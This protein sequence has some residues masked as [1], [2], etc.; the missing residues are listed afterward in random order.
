MNDATW[1]PLALS[2]RWADG[3]KVHPGFLIVREAKKGRRRCLGN[4]QRRSRMSR[5]LA[6]DAAISLG[7]S[8]RPQTEMGRD[9]RGKVNQ[10]TEPRKQSPINHNE[11]STVRR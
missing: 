11:L 10:Q 4:G 2:C 9:N 6:S 1:P 5:G 3:L 8:V 7:F